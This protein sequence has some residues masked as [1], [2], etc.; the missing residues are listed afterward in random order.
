M[1]NIRTEAVNYIESSPFALLVTVG[2]E[3]KPCLRHIGPLVNIGLDI[4]FVTR[5]DSQKVKQIEVNPLITLYFQ[6]S[7]QTVEEF[8]SIAVS[9]KA[10]RLPDG[11]EF[12]DVLEKLG[13]KSPGYKK[14]ISSE[15]FKVWAIYKISSKSLECTD[16]SK[17]TK[18]VKV[19]I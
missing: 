1:S 4:Y 12:D 15:G 2:D 18:T 5:I 16:L 14:Y 19:N 11:D 3:L 8:K 7:N 6:R 9:G 17:S 10:V 13:E